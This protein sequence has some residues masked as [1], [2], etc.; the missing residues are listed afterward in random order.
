V[1]TRFTAWKGV[2]DVIAAVARIG[3]RIA[4]FSVDLI[5]DGPMKPR[6]ARMVKQ[7]NLNGTIR[8]VDPVPYG[9]PFLTLLRSYHVV[10]VPTRGLEEARVVYDAAASGCALIHSA[11]P[12]L[13]GACGALAVRWTHKPGDPRSL[14]AAIT[15][16]L[17]RREDW[18][19]AGLD[20]LR[21]MRGRTIEAMHE[22]RARFLLELRQERGSR[23]P[24][25]SSAMDG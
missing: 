22:K 2:D 16:A 21:L 20:G 24:S 6:L 13:E 4:E 12:T 1:P 23:Q 3:A 11:T 14:A 8:F 18:T 5:G 19:R 15:D 9:T 17:D 25:P 10:L 7:A